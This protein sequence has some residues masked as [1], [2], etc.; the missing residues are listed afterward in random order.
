MKIMTWKNIKN[1]KLKPTLFHC[2]H[3]TTCLN[4]L[5]HIYSTQVCIDSFVQ[6]LP[7]LER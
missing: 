6:I 7:T 5:H 3:S 2:F 1:V 4:M